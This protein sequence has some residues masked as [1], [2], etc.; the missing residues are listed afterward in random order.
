MIACSKRFIH[1]VNLLLTSSDVEVDASR[2][3]GI[4]ALM[5]ASSSGSVE[6]VQSLLRAGADVNK[7]CEDDWS[8]LMYATAGMRTAPGYFSGQEPM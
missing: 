7:I 4:R 1:C 3:H 6:C 5:D 8:A 2:C